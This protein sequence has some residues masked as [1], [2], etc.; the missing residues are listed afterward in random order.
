MIRSRV[1]VAFVALLALADA[2]AIRSTV[3]AQGAAPVDPAAL[4]LLPYLVA[5]VVWVFGTF[6]AYLVA[7]RGIIG[8]RSGYFLAAAFPA[9]LANFVVGEKGRRHAGFEILAH[10]IA[11]C[12]RFAERWILEK[13][14]EPNLGEQGRQ[15]VFPVLPCR[16]LT[17]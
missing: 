13:L 15:V 2:P 3:A 7:V 9:V 6:P 10:A 1:A 17:R 8:E 4:S 5:Y 12:V 16:T 14:L 11:V